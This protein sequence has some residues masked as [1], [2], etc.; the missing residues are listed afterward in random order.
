MN[1]LPAW[2]N[3]GALMAQYAQADLTDQQA[4]ATHQQT[5]Q[6]QYGFDQMKALNDIWS[7]SL[8]PDGKPDEMKFYAL[9]KAAGLSPEHMAT[10]RNQELATQQALQQMGGARAGQ[11]AFGLTPEAAQ[12]SD[13]A[14][15]GDRFLNPRSGDSDL[16]AS[17]PSQPAQAAPQELT[18]DQKRDEFLK[19]TFATQSAPQA[20]PAMPSGLPSSFNAGLAKS[21]GVQRPAKPAPVMDASGDRV[22]SENRPM[23]V[24]QTVLAPEAKLTDPGTYDMPSP[25]YGRIQAVLATDNGQAGQRMGTPPMPEIPA[26]S[27]MDAPTMRAVAEGLRQS[28]AYKG[29]NLPGPKMESAWQSFA[30][31]EFGKVLASQPVMQMGKDGQ[32]DVLKYEQDRQKY[33]GDLQAFPNTLKAKVADWYQKT[34]ITQPGERLGQ[35]S[36]RQTM[37]Q[38]KV[39]FEQ[40]QDPIQAARADGFKLVNP[41][42]VD[43]YQDAR[44]VFDWLGNTKTETDE[45]LKEL[46]AKGA[47]DSDLLGT[48]LTALTQSAKFSEGIGTENAE[49]GFM[50][51]MRRDKALGDIASTS[52]GLKDFL[53][54][55]GKNKLGA[56]SQQ[57]L[58]QNLSSLLGTQI[59]SGKTASYL[60][61]LRG[62]KGANA[63]IEGWAKAGQLGSEK[64]PYPE[65]QEPPV[66]GWYTYKGAV[67]QRRK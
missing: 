17:A 19:K 56:Q 46:K 31:S 62:G 54:N 32:P 59:E 52:T 33:L 9:G 50:A 2:Q 63:T 3:P 49:K 10:Y 64:N 61:S 6:A 25:Q 23:D 18:P 27:S 66:G 36:T 14:A 60:K 47:I 48:K 11:R 67:I 38:G 24:G 58:L 28:G 55:V 22:G 65:G 26:L 44:G 15:Q 41:K 20:N 16:G 1:Q 29:N 42:N 5:Q 53:E 7:Q 4:R 34:N 12:P 51:T 45:L 40:E 43:K 13:Y 35:A 21:L 8:G 37:H 57:F 39:T 30:K